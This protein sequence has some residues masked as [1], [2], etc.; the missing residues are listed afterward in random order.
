MLLALVVACGPERQA[1]QRTSLPDSASPASSAVASAPRSS[2][3][4]PRASAEPAPASSCAG[5]AP[6]ACARTA[7][8]I[9]DQITYRELVCRTAEDRC[10]AS[11]RHAD[12]IGVDADP[13]ADASVVAAARARCEGTQLCVATKGSCACACS[14]LG[15]C[16]CECGGAYLPRCTL[17]GDAEIYDGRPPAEITRSP[18]AAWGSALVAVRRASRTAGFVVAPLPDPAAVVGNDRHGIESVLGT[19]TSCTGKATPSAPCKSAD[20]VFY[21]LYRLPIDSVGGGPELLI[22]YD[23]KRVA[24]Q[25]IITQTR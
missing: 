11:V 4:P 16:K 21:S 10:E 9:L 25:A 19:P 7:G 3:E 20:Q 12:L 13:A 22:T 2:A 1:P 18:L 8:C 23:A 6:I 24:T 14:L 15:N 17:R 5:L